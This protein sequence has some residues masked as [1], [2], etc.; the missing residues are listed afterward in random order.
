MI[1]VY[2]GLSCGLQGLGQV[3]L[4]LK[5]REM[6]CTSLGRGKEGGRREFCTTEYPPKISG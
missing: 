6:S 5:S 4:L 2:F 1:L 3:K